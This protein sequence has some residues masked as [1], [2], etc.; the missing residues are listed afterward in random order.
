MRIEPS[1][2]MRESSIFA[3]Q[4][5]RSLAAVGLGFL[6]GVE[7]EAELVDVGPV[8]LDGAVELLAGDLELGGP[9]G[10]VGGHLRVNFLGVMRACDVRTFVAV[11][12]GIDSVVV[13]GLGG[14][15]D[16]VFGV[17]DVLDVA[18]AVVILVGHG[19]FLFSV[20]DRWMSIGCVGMARLFVRHA[21]TPGT[22]RLRG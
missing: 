16:G 4:F 18:V 9:I 8:G 10:D 15:E 1:R 11:I 19:S 22:G 17:G 21:S 2:G 14:G 6:V 7:G 12:I 13:D 5:W 20:S 3:L